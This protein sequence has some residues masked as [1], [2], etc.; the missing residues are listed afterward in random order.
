MK[1]D[2]LLILALAGCLG[3]ASML[4][5]LGLAI[6]L[7][8]VL[9][10]LLIV[11]FA[12][13]VLRYARSNTQNPPAVSWLSTGILAAGISLITWQNHRLS[14]RWG[15]WDAWAMW[16]FHARFLADGKHWT[17][18]FQS[19]QYDHPDYPLGLPALLAFISRLSGGH[20]W[21][22]IAFAL[23]FL[24]TLSIP[25]LIF[26]L[27]HRKRLVVAAAT[28]IVFAFDDFYLLR[29][30]SQYADTM[31]AA[32]FLM[33]LVSLS[34]AGGDKR[35]IAAGIFFAGCAAWTKNEGI[36]LALLLVLFYARD[37]FSRQNL[38]YTAIGIVLPLITLAVFKVIYATSNDLFQHSDRSLLQQISDVHRYELIWS[39]FRKISGE[40]FTWTVIAMSLY[41][42]A[43]ILGKR[44]PDRPMLLLLTCLAAFLATYIFTPYDP[45]W[46]LHTSLNRLL[47]QLMPSFVYL[48]GLRL[49]EYR[50][51]WFRSNSIKP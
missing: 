19:L 6:H 46:H 14:T 7:P 20:G 1:K 43:S 48:I 4:Y 24:I 51:P 8:F 23:H 25:V 30:V 22:H 33:A 36:V 10:V 31:L 34:Y 50:L 32:Y 15:D 26:L 47:H 29:G 37:F 13:M 5:F 2:S 45:A 11:A 21:M 35:M 3:G 17:N 44:R 49:C 38:R 41:V 42:V 39:Y 16:N 27:L 9:T 12:I 28:L 18:L 40:Y